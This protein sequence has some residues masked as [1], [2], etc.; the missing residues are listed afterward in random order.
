MIKK[1]ENDFD[2][3]WNKIDEIIDD[4][5]KFN[6]YMEYSEYNK[7]NQTMGTAMVF[8]FR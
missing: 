2:N 5:H 8:K 6:G 7:E 4:H 3:I 1:F